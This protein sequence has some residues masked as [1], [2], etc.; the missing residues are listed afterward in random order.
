[1]HDELVS[2]VFVRVLAA[3]DVQALVAP[4]FHIEGIFSNTCNLVFLFKSPLKQKTKIVQY[5]YN[6]KS[7]VFRFECVNKKNRLIRVDWSF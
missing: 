3:V 4:E 7:I 1:M 2:L 6:N 5:K